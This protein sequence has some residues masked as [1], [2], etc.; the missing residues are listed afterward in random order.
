M[1]GVGF[2]SYQAYLQT[3]TG[4]LIATTAQRFIWTRRGKVLIRL[5]VSL[6]PPPVFSSLMLSLLPHNQGNVWFFNDSV[7]I[8]GTESGNLRHFLLT[9]F[10]RLP[11][12]S[13]SYCLN[14]ELNKSKIPSAVNDGF[15][16]PAGASRRSTVQF[17]R[18]LLSLTDDSNVTPVEA[19]MTFPNLQWQDGFLR[20]WGIV[21]T[22]SGR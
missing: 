3:Y 11:G 14:T 1:R 13:G 7:L 6:L 4:S 16:S 12:N 15:P 21:T 17:P 9:C 10:D 18:R 2:I 20:M 19:Y 5:L 22:N 8:T